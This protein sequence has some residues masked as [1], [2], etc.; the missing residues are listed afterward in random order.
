MKP[1]SASPTLHVL[2]KRWY[3]RAPKKFNTNLLINDVHHAIFESGSP[4]LLGPSHSQIRLLI[5]SEYFE[6]VLWHYFSEDVSLRHLELIVVLLIQKLETIANLQL[7]NLA[8]DS[9]FDVLVN[10]LIQTTL[11]VTDRANFKLFGYIVRF[12]GVLY[13]KGRDIP[14]VA[15]K[16]HPLFDITIWNNIT[17]YE[18]LFDKDSQE[19]YNKKLSASL[20]QLKSKIEFNLKNKWIF[21]LLIGS[22]KILLESEFCKTPDFQSFVESILSLLTIKLSQ[23]EENDYFRVFYNAVQFLPLVVLHKDKFNDPRRIEQLADVLVYYELSKNLQ[24]SEFFYKL[25]EYVFSLFP[26]KSHELFMNMPSV[27]AY[28]PNKLKEFLSQFTIEELTTL[29]KKTVHLESSKFLSTTFKQDE[30]AIIIQILISRTFTTNTSLEFISSY[31]ESTFDSS[32]SCS[33]Y[34]NS[35]VHLTPGKFLSSNDI[36]SDEHLSNLKIQIQHDISNH[37]L[38]VL[39][40]IDIDPKLNFKGKSKY[41]YQIKDLRSQQGTE[42]VFN[43][44]RNYNSGNGVVALIELVLPNKFAREDRVQKYGLNLIRLG[45]ITSTDGQK[46]T[47]VRCN[48]T[49]DSLVD[50]VKYL[51]AVP[52][53]LGLKILHSYNEI[54]IL[55]E[56]ST[57]SIESILS[58]A[59]KK[60]HHHEIENFKRR[61]VD[62]GASQSTEVD[63]LDSIISNNYTLVK[64]VRYTG[65]ESVLTNALSYLNFERTII[66]APTETYVKRLAGLRGVDEFTY[67]GFG[68]EDELKEIE[69]RVRSSMKVIAQLFDHA[70]GLKETIDLNS[71]DYYEFQIKS[72]WTKYL[73]E[74]KGKT[75]EILKN[76]PFADGKSTFKS[77]KDITKSY[78]YLLKN[79]NFLRIIAPIW[80]KSG[81][82]TTNS[83]LWKYLYRKFNPIITLEDYLSFGE[84][85]TFTNIFIIDGTPEC[86]PV[87]ARMNQGEVKRLIGIGGSI[88]NFRQEH[89]F[90]LNEVHGVRNEFIAGQPIGENNFRNFNPGFKYNSQLIEAK[91]QVEEAE[92]CVNLY[93]YMVLLG[94]PTSKIGIW[95]SSE[96]QRALITEI[97]DSKL[98][99]NQG[100]GFSFEAPEVILNDKYHTLDYSD[101]AIIGLGDGDYYNGVP[102][103]LGNY[104][105][106]QPHALI[107]SQAPIPTEHK[108]QICSGENFTVS[109]RKVGQFYTIEDQDHLQEYVDQMTAARRK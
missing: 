60:I 21:N 74:N 27:Y 36:F 79:I 10:R 46:G 16:I 95:V 43:L 38:N 87:V 9:R 28:T 93:Q 96:Q 91:S 19:V 72:T 82:R 25:Q 23:V 86:L 65:I 103:R 78:F 106:G 66:I 58:G 98:P 80:L 85:D 34:S 52:D 94:Y 26:T 41:F 88:V 104:Y 109:E 8:G 29:M 101:Y 90:T 32:I 15:A 54:H 6:R 3:P 35:S 63:L 53:S 75:S 100:K 49:V 4:S 42:Y 108:L 13:S 44:N 39:K 2:A 51:I 11:I 31:D 1:I 99:E 83:H 24:E 59:P 14:E 40:R 70:E 105:V 12:V 62:S 37:I 107:Q 5:E 89:I 76:Y 20:E 67:V 84:L 22:S 47:G 18:E 97:F 56:D 45:K 73:E 68:L 81:L 33:K 50:R 69:K 102:G 7:Q 30:K 92:F 77:F 71:I 57:S 48:Y 55:G 64:S 17:G 61:K